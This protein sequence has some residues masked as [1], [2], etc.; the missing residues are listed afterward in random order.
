MTIWT[1]GDSFS[2][3]FKF[4]PDT[5][6]Q[7]VAANLNQSV[8]SYSRPVTSIEYAFHSFNRERPNIQ[9]NDI[10]IVTL[11]NIDRRWFFKDVPLRTA[12][13]LKDK[14]LRAY[15]LYSK[16]LTNFDVQKTYLTN[17][18]Y[19]LNSFSKSKT[20]HTIVIGNFLEYEKYLDSISKGLLHINVAKGPLSFVS[21]REWRREIIEHAPIEWFMKFDRRLNHIS[22][23]NH[24]L[25]ANKIL[26]NIKNKTVIDLN[27]GLATNF[28]TEELFDDP[29]YRKVELFDDEWKRTSLE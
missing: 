17:F 3:H 2:R 1:F 18:L 4:L 8:K 29:D 24:I 10:I 13:D 6:V 20:L 27:T 19:N 22:R 5:W 28:L 25:L 15:Q 7:H 12:L 14:D 21:D 16:Y 26:D 11:T 23:T 9:P